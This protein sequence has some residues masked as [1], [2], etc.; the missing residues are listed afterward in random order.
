MLVCS[1]LLGVISSTDCCSVIGQ[2]ISFV[3]VLVLAIRLCFKIRI[4]RKARLPE[5]HF[6]FF[7]AMESLRLQDMDL[8][9]FCQEDCLASRMIRRAFARERLKMIMSAVDRVRSMRR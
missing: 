1:K 5:K 8:Q 6:I 7:Q 3:L 9:N 2:D 4:R